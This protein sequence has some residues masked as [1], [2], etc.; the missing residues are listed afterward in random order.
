[1]DLAEKAKNAAD[2]IK[3]AFIER[4]IAF[5]SP[6]ESNQLFPVLNAEQI[7]MLEQHFEFYVWKKIDEEKAA[8]RLITSW[9]TEKQQIEKIINLIKEL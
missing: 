8:I 1:M 6:P 7:R 5:L 4:N 9:A 2:Q 3:N